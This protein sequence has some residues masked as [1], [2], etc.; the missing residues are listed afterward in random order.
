MCGEQGIIAV[1]ETMHL[2]NFLAKFANFFFF[3]MLMLR[4]LVLQEK[5]N[6]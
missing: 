1:R 6:Y 2:V 5:I 4:Y 3:R